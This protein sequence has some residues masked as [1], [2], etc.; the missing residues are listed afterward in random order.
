[1]KKEAYSNIIVLIEDQMQRSV[2]QRYLE[3]HGYGKGLKYGQ[4]RVRFLQSKKGV[5]S[6]EQFVRQNYPK[7]Y[8]EFCKKKNNQNIALIVVIDAD[9]KTVQERFDQLTNKG[10]YYQDQNIAILIPKRNIESWLAFWS[11]GTVDESTNYKPRYPDNKTPVIPSELIEKLQALA[12]QSKYLLTDDK[13]DSL[14]FAC[15]QITRLNLLDKT[16]DDQRQ[17]H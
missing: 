7:E 17:K 11:G 8:K 6:G 1:M 5:G 4:Y 3:C 2:V 10:E 14:N 16:I 15:E 12:L 13:P 9:T